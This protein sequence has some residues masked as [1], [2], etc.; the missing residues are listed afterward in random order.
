[1]IDPDLG[2]IKQTILGGEKDM[3]QVIVMISMVMLG[4]ALSG[5]IGEFAESAGTIADSSM[6]QIE[7]IA[8]PPVR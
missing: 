6:T 2:Y 3:K 7:E 8:V 4:L 1:M 5:L